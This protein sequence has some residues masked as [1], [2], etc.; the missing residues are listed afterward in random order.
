MN[1]FFKEEFF[2]ETGAGDFICFVLNEFMNTIQNKA[3]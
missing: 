2:F 3:G 1:G